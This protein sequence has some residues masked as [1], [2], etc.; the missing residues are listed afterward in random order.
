[1]SREKIAIN[2]IDAIVFDCDGVLTNN[3]VYLNQNGTES[4]AFNRSDGLGFDALRELKKPT[5]IL[6]S[7]KNPV[8]TAR[9]EKLKIEAIQG[10]DNKT[11]AIKT[12]AST[13]QFSLDRILYV[14]NDINDY[15][16]MQTVGYTA[17]PSDSHYLIKQI[18]MINLKSNGGQGIVRELLEQVFNLD[19]IK[20]LYNFRN[21]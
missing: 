10:V 18:S 15:H 17:C 1:M 9:A 16:V 13:N 3:Y 8:V 4:V 19:L 11:K 20:I 6:S 5:F 21:I 14:G 12:L 2:D 7:E